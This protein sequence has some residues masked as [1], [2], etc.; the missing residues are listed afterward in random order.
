MRHDI[1]TE[2]NADRFREHTQ[3]PNLVL[4]PIEK[5][6]DNIFKVDKKSTVVFWGNEDGNSIKSSTVNLKTIGK[7]D[8]TFEDAL[9]VL[10]TTLP[11]SQAFLIYLDGN[12][13]CRAMVPM[14]R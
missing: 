13:I 12:S 2:E 14:K 3:M 7:F 9:S 1:I 11:P 6:D 4:Y 8:G 10:K 5:I